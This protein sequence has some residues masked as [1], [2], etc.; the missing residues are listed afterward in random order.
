MSA[1][2]EVATTTLDNIATPKKRMSIFRAMSATPGSGPVTITF[3][4]TESNGTWIVSQW[5]G[6]NTTGSDGAGAVGQSVTNVADAVSTIGTTLAPLGAP[7]N[8][9]Y[10]A[11]GTTGSAI[12][13]SPGAGFA[14][15]A[16][17]KPNESPNVIFESLF[18]AN[19]TAPSASWTGAFAAAILAIEIKAGP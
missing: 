5:T 13:I 9:A 17:Q 3:P 1:W 15:I 14:E 11:I 16:E 6:V 10:A 12:G 8:V 2:V 7:A 19:Q 4:T 18:A